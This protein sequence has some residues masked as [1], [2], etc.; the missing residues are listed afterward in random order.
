MDIV[1]SSTGSN[2]TLM[3]IIEDTSHVLGPFVIGT[4]CHEKHRDICVEIVQK[5][6]EGRAYNKGGMAL[7][8]ALDRAATKALRSA[9]RLRSGLFKVG[10]FEDHGY[11]KSCMPGTVKRAIAQQVDDGQLR[12]DL[13]WWRAVIPACCFATEPVVLVLCDKFY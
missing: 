9:K 11:W 4:Q 2:L 6:E 12:P 5:E 7:V 10:W 1:Q 3:R 8:N 13:L